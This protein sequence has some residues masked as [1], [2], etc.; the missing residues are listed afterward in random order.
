MITNNETPE[1]RTK[2]DLDSGTSAIWI[3]A[4]I[5]IGFILRVIAWTNSANLDPDSPLY[6]Q[7]AKAIYLHQWHLL[8]NCGLSY[9]ASYP[10]FIA[11]LYHIIPNWEVCARLISLFFGT[12]LLIPL[13]LLLKCFLDRN[14]SALTTLIFAVLP[15]FVGRSVDVLKDPTCWFFLV[16]GL[17]FFVARMNQENRL[18]L[19]LSSLSFLMASWARIESVLFIA[20]SLLYLLYSER[21]FKNLLIFAA[22][23]LLF[24][25]AGY[26]AA[27][28]TDFPINNLLRGSEIID[29]ISIVSSQY[30]NLRNELKLLAD[31]QQNEWMNFFI[32]SARTNIW[33]IALGI[34]LNRLLEAS[35]HIFF[36]ILLIGLGDIKNKVEKDKRLI[37]FL[38]LALSSLFLL[39]IH[40]IQTW[41]MDN[42]FMAIFLFPCAVF[43]A[44]GLKKVMEWLQ[45]FFSHKPSIVLF[46]IAFFII[47]STLPKNLEQ[48]EHDKAVFKEIGEV[49]AKREGNQNTIS[50][51]ASPTTQRWVSFYANYHS[52]AVFCPQPT[53]ENCWKYFLNDPHSFYQTLKKKNIKY[54]L[55]TQRQ[56]PKEI[57]LF[58]MPYYQNLQELGRWNHPDTGW[59]ILFK[60]K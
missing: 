13:Y 60:V 36:I 23:I 31:S 40:I 21:K 5:L 42:R 38:A 3:T 35:F 51:S 19:L 7:Q 50:I 59:M 43:I 8:T 10:I 30:Q 27:L 24:T 15:L 57:D 2:Q 4:V 48:R 18:F 12:A 9:I 54:F 37:Y 44:Y 53:E 25:L 29:R 47:F 39:Y 58:K 20:V 46:I 22:P 1:S 45:K 49:I 6:I 14:L 56:W 17:Y 11:L 55:W 28:F 41:I 16:L 33:L 52:E 26:V 32:Y 34:L